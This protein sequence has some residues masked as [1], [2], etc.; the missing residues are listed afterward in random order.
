MNNMFRYRDFT[1]SFLLDLRCGG[2]AANN[3]INPGTEYYNR[4][5]QLD[6]PYWTPEN[7]LMIVP[8]LV[9]LIRVV[10]DFMKS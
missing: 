1:L 2:Y 10:M 6:L 4:C 5:N 9:T 3:W 8:V 7:P